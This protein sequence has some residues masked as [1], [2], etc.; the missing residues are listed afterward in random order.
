M[1]ELKLIGL[2]MTLAYSLWC[3]SFTKKSKDGITTVF[4]EE[5]YL[6]ILK[7]ML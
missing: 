3:S 2:E 5:V 4:S 6:R 1:I 7:N